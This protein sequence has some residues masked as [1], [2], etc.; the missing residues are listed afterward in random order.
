ME[1]PDLPEWLDFALVL[2]HIY[3]QELGRSCFSDP[4]AFTNWTY[5]WAWG[6][7]EDWIRARI[8]ESPEW[9]AKHD[10]ASPVPPPPEPT[11]Q[12]PA[13]LDPL[14]WMGPRLV[15]VTDA[16]DGRI[17][18]RLSSYWANA[19]VE[20]DVI[21]VFCGHED[22]LVRFF[23]VGPGSG[24]IERRG[25]M[26][27]PYRGETEGWYFD[28]EGWV[29]LFNGP[30]FKRFN[31]RTG[32]NRLIYDIREVQGIPRNTDLW[33]PH[34]S[35]DGRVHSATVRQ[36]VSTGKYPYIGT[37]VCRDGEV[38]YFPAQGVLDESAL[39]GDGEDLLIKEGNERG[40]DQLS[41]D[42]RIITLSNRNT[43]YILDRGRAMGHSDCGPNY[44]V[45]EADKPDPGMCG[46]WDLRAPL[47]M[48]RFHPLFPTLNMGYVAVRG[49][50]IL[51]SS[52]TQ[53]RLV[54]RQT[55]AI[56]TLMDH[57]GGPDYDDRV[58]GNLSPC[59]RVVCFMSSFGGPRRDIYLLIL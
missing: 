4:Q 45:G 22:G 34:S 40:F 14:P 15:K 31:P 8:Q 20:G 21:W 51:H 3:Q 16:Q 55:A 27:I 18:P 1:H 52:Q 49:E 2:D 54:D 57:G 6:Q 32:E 37:V 33:Q 12:P 26:G 59:G 36:I 24:Q 28:L 43:R 10:G 29:Y 13:V 56:T 5:H 42:N 11:P 39:S 58:K 30:E 48:E 50:R 47:T 19:W 9:A 7:S 46:W 53:L 38:I 23:R 25:S 35:D 17:P 41:D 44:V